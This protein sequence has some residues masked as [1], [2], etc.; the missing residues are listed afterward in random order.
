MKPVD[1][2]IEVL[3]LVVDQR[4]RLDGPQMAELALEALAQHQ[5]DLVLMDVNMPVMDGLEATRRFRRSEQAGRKPIIAMTANAMPNDR[6]D[7]LAAGMDDY[8]SKPLE[9]AALQRLLKHHMFV[10]SGST[11]GRSTAPMT[12]ADASPQIPASFDYVSALAAADQEV[13]DIVADIFLDQWA[14]DIETLNQSLAMGDLN[15]G[16]HVAHALKGTLGLFGARPAVD[17]AYRIET[18]A[19][20][21]EAAGLNEMSEAMVGEVEKMIVAL[22]RARS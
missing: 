15:A 2:L 20:R 11:G 21:G 3:E 5:F 17:L 1:I 6:A 14:V 8:I 19:A 10:K 22:R 18:Q 4:H 12:P 9:A 16:M 7:C 13:V